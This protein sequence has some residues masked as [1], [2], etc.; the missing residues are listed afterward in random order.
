MIYG[1]YHLRFRLLFFLACLLQFGFQGASIAGLN[2]AYE[3]WKQGDHETAYREYSI[4]AEQGDAKAEYALGNLYNRGEGVTKDTTMAAA[5]IKK[6]A[7]QGLPKAQTRL[8]ELYSSGRGVPRDPSQAVYWIRQAAQQDDLL[9]QILLG[10]MYS[11]GKD[12]E[13]NHCLAVEWYQK[14]VNQGNR[15]AQYRLAWMYLSGSCLPLDDSKA[16][17]LLELSAK[18]GYGDASIKLAEMYRSGDHVTQDFEKAQH[19]YRI[20]GAEGS[21][22]RMCRARQGN[23]EDC[24]SD[25]IFRGIIDDVEWLIFVT[26]VIIAFS[27]PLLALLLL[28]IDVH[29][30]GKILVQMII[31]V[32]A[33][34]GLLV[35]SSEPLFL[36][37]YTAIFIGLYAFYKGH[38]PARI[39][40]GLLFLLAV[41]V[42]LFTAVMSGATYGSDD[43][44]YLADISMLNVISHFFIAMILFLSTSITVF[45]SAQRSKYLGE[46]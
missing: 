31:F 29:R 35:S 26:L 28:P 18:Q 45:Q 39:I 25:E 7:E 40:L 33:G 12:V 17:M 46:K 8:G 11:L 13:R 9:A 42:W 41:P 24:S 36:I 27:I 19:W 10:E 21:L 32:V 5:W 23:M 22:I 4:L 1:H 34:S 15:V 43:E 38:V 16:L 30:R 20:A 2:D 14:A 6:A 3:A 37:P 44:F